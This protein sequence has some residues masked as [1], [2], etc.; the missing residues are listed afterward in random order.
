QPNATSA[1]GA[2]PEQDA[3]AASAGRAAWAAADPAARAYPAEGPFPAA[4]APVAMEA[5]AGRGASVAARTA[6]TSNA[7][8]AAA[9][10]GAAT[11]TDGADGVWTLGSGGASVTTTGS[12]GGGGATS[13]GYSGSDGGTAA[14]TGGFTVFTSRGGGSTGAVGLGGSAFFAGAAPFF[15]PPFGAGVSA[16]MSPPGRAMP[17]WRAR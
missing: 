1:R 7:G 6:D 4:C 17:R 14:A 2:H 13:I 15:T 12:G 5:D 9:R 11:A 3:P 16:K 8:E 10:P